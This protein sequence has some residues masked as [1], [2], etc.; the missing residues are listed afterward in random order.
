MFKVGGDLRRQGV[1]E[2]GAAVKIT[3]D[4]VSSSDKRYH[5]HGFSAY[6][7]DKI[8]IDRSIPDIRHPQ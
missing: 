4:E 3:K 2:Q 5:S 6:V 8:A 7:S 1:G